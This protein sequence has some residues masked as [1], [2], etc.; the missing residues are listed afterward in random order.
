M[1]LGLLLMKQKKEGNGKKK[2]QKQMNGEYVELQEE[3]KNIMNQ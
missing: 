3:Q 1:D 2:F